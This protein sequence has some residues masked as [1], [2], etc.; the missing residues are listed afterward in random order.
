MGKI[1]ETKSAQNQFC[2]LTKH[3]VDSNKTNK[4]QAI[5]F[6]STVSHHSSVKL[7]FIGG[8]EVIMT[9]QATSLTL[10]AFI[11][12]WMR[13][14]QSVD[15][16]GSLIEGKF[17][18]VSSGIGCVVIV[19]A[20]L[21]SCHKRHKMLSLDQFPSQISVP[22]TLASAI[23][24]SVSGTERR[25]GMMRLNICRKTLGI[26]CGLRGESEKRKCTTDISWLV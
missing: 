8:N 21:M 11:T 22:P 25:S 23:D 13:L 24:K 12:A 14:L 20:D 26:L 9:P 3:R 15:S 6:Y 17:E 5:R 10:M 19:W 1:F 7:E 4:V 2:W 18:N 16:N